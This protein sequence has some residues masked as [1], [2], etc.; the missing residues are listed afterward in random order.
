MDLWLIFFVQC[1]RIRRRFLLFET[2]FV[3]DKFLGEASLK[4]K[5]TGTSIFT[6]K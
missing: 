5:F 6:N 3:K 4:N 1:F 2:L